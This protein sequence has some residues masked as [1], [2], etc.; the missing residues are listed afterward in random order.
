M[1][2]AGWGGGSVGGGRPTK[3]GFCLWL[4]GDEPLVMVKVVS[5]TPETDS[6]FTDYFLRVPPGIQTARE[7][8]AWTFGKTPD[9]YDPEQES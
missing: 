5:A 6:S 1:L 8:V 3:L 4:P 7:A 9:V 2:G